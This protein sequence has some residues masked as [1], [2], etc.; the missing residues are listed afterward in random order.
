MSKTWEQREAQF[1]R[2]PGW[3]IGKWIVGV[4]VFIMLLST[5]IWGFGVLTAPVSGRGEAV[6]RIESA[7]NRIFKQEM[8]EELYQDVGAYQAQLAALGKGTENYATIKQGLIN[9]C[10]DTVATY[11]AEAR[12]VSSAKFRSIDLP[13]SLT[14]EECAA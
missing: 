11:N 5:A 6:K 8:F 2:R 9:K 14:G 13:E 7:E 12:K 10:L 3:T 4:V 1:E